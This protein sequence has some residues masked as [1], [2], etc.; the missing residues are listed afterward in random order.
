MRLVGARV[1][2]ATFPQLSPIFRQNAVVSTIL[3]TLSFVQQSWVEIML[4][5]CL[6]STSV[7]A[8]QPQ[9]F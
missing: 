2:I 9:V 3:E 8:R 1:T 7:V 6:E 5:G 4:R